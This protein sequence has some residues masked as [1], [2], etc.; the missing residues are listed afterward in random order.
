MGV[1]R[2][3]LGRSSMG[4]GSSRA[5]IEL[6]IQLDGEIAPG[7][8]VEIGPPSPLSPYTGPGVRRQADAGWTFHVERVEGPPALLAYYELYDHGVTV[9]VRAN[10]SEAIDA[11]IEAIDALLR[12]ADLDRAQ[13]EVVALSQLLEVA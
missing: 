10:T 4:G 13:T 6:R 7:V 11:A 9:S 2:D 1:A 12:S 5:G 3:V 8:T